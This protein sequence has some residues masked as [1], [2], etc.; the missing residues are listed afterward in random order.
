MNSDSL[1]CVTIDV[2]IFLQL[3]NTLDPNVKVK[4]ALQN[5]KSLWKSRNLVRYF[6]K[7]RLQS[8]V[9]FGYFAIFN[10][11]LNDQKFHL[12]FIRFPTIC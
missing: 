12:R 10:W 5:L 4:T 7:K 1:E 9:Y 6:S 3:S 8:L 11:S 2:V